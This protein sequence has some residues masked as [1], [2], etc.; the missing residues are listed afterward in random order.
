MVSP[1]YQAVVGGEMKEIKQKVPKN[2]VLYF[3]NYK[4]KL[5]INGFKL[6]KKLLKRCLRGISLGLLAILLKQKYL[7]R[8]EFNQS[9]K[10]V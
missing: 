1:Y 6:K 4:D 3:L 5:Y 2:S 8:K 9:R 10:G 7:T